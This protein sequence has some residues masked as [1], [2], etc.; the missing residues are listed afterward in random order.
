MVDNIS[1]G[2]VAL[3]IASG[4]HKPAF[5]LNPAA[6]AD[7]R[8]RLE[9]DIAMIRRLWAGETV[10]FP[11]VDGE[12]VGVVAYPRPIQRKLDIWLTASSSDSWVRAGKLGANVLCLLGSSDAQLEKLVTSYRSAR[13]SFGH[14]PRGGE[15]TVMVHTYLHPDLAVAKC[16]VRVPLMNYLKEHMTQKFG[17]CGSELEHQMTSRQNELLEFGFEKRFQDSLIGPKEKCRSLLQ[18]L[19]K[20]G[21]TE[22]ACLVDFGLSKTD[23]LAGVHLLAELL[24]TK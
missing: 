16:K 12:Q 10:S 5:V 14:D 21:A 24:P 18:K 19:S 8:E 11:G 4:W 7:R 13:A 17:S 15:V 6:F 3:A 20:A 1:G 22:V 23:V 9:R 2:R